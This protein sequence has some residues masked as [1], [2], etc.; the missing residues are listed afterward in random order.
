MA[1][2]NHNYT[3]NDLFPSKNKQHIGP[4]RPKKYLT[5]KERLQADRERK[6]R[7]A[8]K[9]TIT[10]HNDEIEKLTKELESYKKSNKVLQEELTSLK[11]ELYRISKDKDIAHGKFL[12]GSTYSI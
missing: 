8:A 5:E 9:H 10:A 1:L 3:Q 11:E 7:Y 6:Q 12:D 4:G 2:V